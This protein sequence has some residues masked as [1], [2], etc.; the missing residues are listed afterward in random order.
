MNIRNAAKAIILHQNKILLN[1]CYSPG[2]GEYY[3]LPGGGQRP[4]ES[5][6]QALIREC[7]EETGYTVIP[8]GFLALYEEIYTQE[9]IQQQYPRHA[10][11]ILHIFKCRIDQAEPAAPTELDRWQRG[12]VWVEIADLGAITLHPACVCEN[13]CALIQS[14]RP[15]YLG[16]RFTDFQEKA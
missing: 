3:A 7:R 1:R 6:E 16:S 12:S 10:H 2:T 4:G 8:E 5:M 15:V 9:S 13:L 14:D 11:K